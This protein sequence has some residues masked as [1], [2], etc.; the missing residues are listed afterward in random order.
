MRVCRKEVAQLHGETFARGRVIMSLEDLA[1]FVQD[2]DL[3]RRASAEELTDKT[4][5]DP[6]IA[7]T[8]GCRSTS[9]PPVRREIPYTTLQK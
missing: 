6:A 3:G 7:S 8:V 9:I 5:L 1:R 4:Q 2:C